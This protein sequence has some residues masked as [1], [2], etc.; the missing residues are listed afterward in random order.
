VANTLFK[1][2]REVNSGLVIESSYDSPD[3]T[4]V[5]NGTTMTYSEFKA[6]LEDIYTKMTS[7]EVNVI[8]EKF[9]ILDSATVLYTANCTFLEHFKDGHSFTADPAVMLFI[10]K[11]I[12][13]RWKWIYG[14]ES[15][16]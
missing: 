8:Q 5:F 15:Y 2:C 4:Y 3:F 6:A 7:Q 16:G 11:K 9:A 1:G 10:F 13:G 14:V 12:D